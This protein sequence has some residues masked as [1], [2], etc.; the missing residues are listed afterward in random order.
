MSATTFENQPEMP[1]KNHD[2]IGLSKFG[3]AGGL[4]GLVGVLASIALI[5]SPATRQ[6]MI[7][8]YLF[9]WTFWIGIT[10]GCFGLSLLYYTVRGSWSLP[11]I[12]L[13]EAG[14]SPITFGVM[15]ALFLPILG[16][17]P[18]L[19]EWANPEALQGPHGHLIE[20]RQ[21]YLNV[22]FFAIRLVFYFVTWALIANKMQ[23]SARKQDVDGNFRHEAKRSSGGAGS[24]VFYVLTI[25][26][27]FTDWV[28]SVDT[29]W[30]STIYG[31]WLM[32]GS[33]LGALSLTTLIVCLNKD[34]APYNDAVTGNVTK[35]FGNMLFVFTLLWAYT[36]L[37]QFLIIWNGNLPE[38]T[39]YYRARSEFGWNIIGLIT[40]VGQF[41]LPFLWLLAPRAKRIGSILAKI[42]AWILVVHVIDVY[43]VVIPSLPTGSIHQRSPGTNLWMDVLALVSVGGFWL[44]AF[45][46]KIGKAPLMPLYDNRLQEAK[47]YEH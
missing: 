16:F 8:S 22:P 41:L 44:L 30:F 10:L 1:S 29:A 15:G 35:D 42:A 45:G 19:Y 31:V 37:S 46:T 2:T 20:H 27:A 26:F 9:G 17:M 11:L 4:L 36:S 24:L 12:R 47:K 43:Q 3:P 40:I 21:P 5:A 18:S 7:G 25:T 6:A 13:W 39:T 14:A 38:F 33:A 28:M 34:K 32:V 23:K